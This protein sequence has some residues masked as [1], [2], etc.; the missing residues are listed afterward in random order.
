MKLQLFLTLLFGGLIFGSLNAQNVGINSTGNAPDA[1]A[2]LDVNFT[3]KGVLI[4][5]VNLNSTSSSSPVSSPENS[6]LVYNNATAND[7]YP[8]Y[9]YWVK[10]GASG[11]WIRIGEGDFWKLTGNAGT[12]PNN[13]GMWNPAENNFIGTTDNADFAFATN[14]YERMRIMSENASNIMR[15]G[16]GTSAPVNYNT[17]DNPSILHLNDWGGTLNDFAVLSLSSMNGTPD[18]RQGVINFAAANLGIG[19]STLNR[20]TATLESYLVD[21]DG[22]KIYGDL[23]FFTNNGDDVSER[24]RIVPKGYVGIGTE[25]PTDKLTVHNGNIR[26][27]TDNTYSPTSGSFYKENPWLYLRNQSTILKAGQG[28]NIIFSASM[29]SAGTPADIA[30][31]EGSREDGVNNST[32]SAL[33]FW[34]RPKQPVKDG[35]FKKRFVI[36]SH[37]HFEFHPEANNTTDGVNDNATAYVILDGGGENSENLSQEPAFYPSKN[38]FGSLGLSGNLWY[39]LYAQHTY[40]SSTQSRKT[41]INLLSE[42]TRQDF[43]NKVKAMEIKTYH[44][45]RDVY[46]SLDNVIGKEVMP[47]LS[48]GLIAEEAPAEITNEEKSAVELYKY[49]SMV[50]VALQEAQKKIERLEKLL[51]EKGIKE[52]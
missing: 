39:K 9:Y 36:D 51:E 20:R 28:G 31:I 29:N 14:G 32:A 33:T 27:I 45:T 37:G 10:N 30:M 52:E 43:Y 19:A 40:N 11:K 1:S 6:L 13:K 21:V 18:S 34:T 26:A 24:M 2:G 49:I 41:D 12:T 50:T 17:G 38:A 35:G 5:R 48:M 44:Y 46:D 8:G 22:N 23:R 3:N 16:M 7:V 25:D 47:E 15:I 42:E 4:P